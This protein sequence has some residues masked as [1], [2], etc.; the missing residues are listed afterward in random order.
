M[1]RVAAGVIAAEEPLERGASLLAEPGRVTKSGAAF[2]NAVAMKITNQTDSYH[3]LTHPGTCIVPAAL[4]VA[5]TCDA[6]GPDFLA[7]LAAG[8]EVQCR[9]ARDYIPTTQARGFRS[10]GVYGVVGAAVAAAKLAGLDLAGIRAAIAL[11]AT[12][13]SGTSECARTGSAENNFQ[14]PLAARNGVLA[15][16]FAPGMPRVAPTAFEGQAG[17]YAA[18]TGAGSGMVT[19]AFTDELARGA[20]LA[21]VTAGLGEHF[22]TMHVAFKPYPTPGYNNPVIETLL[23]GRY[24]LYDEPG[25]QRHEAAPEEVDAFQR[26]V[27][28]VPTRERG[29][30][31]PHITI[32]TR[33]GSVASDAFHGGEL[34]W[35]HA[36]TAARARAAHGGTGLPPEEF[37]RLLEQVGLL[38]RSADVTSVLRIACP[39]L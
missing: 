3:M 14:E 10:A 17:L 7:A 35:D 24:P 26:R 25:V 38:D 4:A 32:R 36:E 31:E 12:A 30:F 1:A 18:F 34:K 20:S 15:A 8:Y 9:L 19:H 16:L 2:A 33:D 37:E 23:D 5:E 27:R 13:A 11:G 22:E 39:A 29:Y 28:I 6:S 21:R